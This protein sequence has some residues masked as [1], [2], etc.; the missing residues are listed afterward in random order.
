MITF[1]AVLKTA[2]FLSMLIPPAAAIAGPVGRI[3]LVE[4]KVTINSAD[5]N[6]AATVFGTV[7]TDDSLALEPSSGI[8]VAFRDN[9]SRFAAKSTEQPMQCKVLNDHLEITSQAV[10]GSSVKALPF[11]DKKKQLIAEAIEELSDLPVAGVTVLRAAAPDESQVC[12][13][14]KNAKLIS[15]EPTFRWP[16]NKDAVLVVTVYQGKDPV[17]SSPQVKKSSLDYPKDKPPLERGK[18]Y[19]WKVVCVGTDELWTEGCFHVALN[20]DFEY[21]K[22]WASSPDSDLQ[23]LA[24]LGYKH[25]NFY[26][27]AIRGFEALAKRYPSRCEFQVSLAELYSKIGNTDES[28]RARKRALE[29]GAEEEKTEEGP[30]AKTDQD[31]LDVLFAIA[32][33]AMVTYR[34]GRPANV[35]DI[36]MLL[37]LSWDMPTA[38]KNIQNDAQILTSKALWENA[39]SQAVKDV[40]ADPS[41]YEQVYASFRSQIDRSMLQLR[42]RQVPS[43][44]T[45]LALIDVAEFQHHWKRFDDCNET[46]R[47][48]S[49]VRADKKI[50]D[51][52]RAR[53]FNLDGRVAL[54]RGALPVATEMFAEALVLRKAASLVA[55]QAETINNLAQVKLCVGDYGAAKALLGNAL[56]LYQTLGPPVPGLPLFD[57]RQ[58]ALINLSI[59]VEGDRDFHRAVAILEELVRER[60]SLPQKSDCD[61]T[62]LNNLGVANYQL[63]KFEA[64][65]SCLTRATLLGKELFGEKHP[66]VLESQVNLAW[67]DVQDHDYRTA[68]GRLQEAWEGFSKDPNKADRATEVRAYLGR[69]HLET[70]D[71]A[72]AETELQSSVDERLKQVK[73][74]L[75]KFESERERIAFLQQLRVHNESIAWPGSLD[76][77]LELAT[78]LNIPAEVQYEN[79]IRWKS[80][81]TSS[82]VQVNDLAGDD[83]TASLGGSALTLAHQARDVRV[84]A[85]TLLASRLPAETALIDFLEIRLLPQRNMNETV[86]DRRFYIAFGL[87]PSG[88]VARFDLGDAAQID[89][90]VM[91]F[92]NRVSSSEMKPFA[93]AGIQLTDTILS[94][95]RNYVENCKTI[96]VI[97]DGIFHRL[98]FGALAG[99]QQ[100]Y[101]IEETAFVTLLNPILIHKSKAVTSDLP[102][103]WLA[104]GGIDYGTGGQATSDKWKALAGTGPEVDALTSLYLQHFGKRSGA[105]VLTGSGA[106]KV[107]IFKHLP[108]KRYVHFATHGTYRD[109]GS[110]AFDADVIDSPLDSMLV[111]ADANK[112]EDVNQATLSA[113]ELVSIDLSKA[114]VVTL[115]ACETGLGE[116]RAGL[117]RIGLVPAFHR[118][119]AKNV[120]GAL[121]KVDDG[122]SRQL[123]ETFYVELFENRTIRPHEALRAAQLQLLRSNE[124]AYNHPFHWSGWVACGH[125]ATE[126][127]SLR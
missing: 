22:E 76:S 74:S 110:D 70:G 87:R 7:H 23:T 41:Q 55:D 115:S 5:G 37:K 105:T 118:A 90:K 85:V 31:Q 103:G 100:K 75:Q 57:S 119:G 29:L 99:M 95:L 104:A 108:D 116:V 16:E 126:W 107:A 98:P 51:A 38:N 25:G 39:I 8:V 80:L 56:S 63:G 40:E 72:K 117:G 3:L 54:E 65:R 34:S 84:S 62:I 17:W 66:S 68:I 28:E 47:K 36:A 2:F 82:A 10:P 35:D 88:E 113:S 93:R 50:S 61:A 43:V 73:Q 42:D 30:N 122:S 49:A 83:T 12:N 78:R 79:V 45:K 89:S 13:P 109:R 92:V 77:Y 97:P 11:A 27:E 44:C 26:D 114:D 1:R 14:P 96:V 18:E 86:K 20:E 112:V 6:R 121:W 127:T 124:S 106:T 120:I 4:G 101:W 59:A 94:P 69:L 58:K 64:A 123:M 52:M 71:A 9:G 125:L 32:N 33:R 111:F 67:L 81:L 15:V 53:I 60:E 48:L 46:L 91:E 24:A 21:L 19:K 102:G